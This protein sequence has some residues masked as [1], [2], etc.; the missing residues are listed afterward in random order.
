MQRPEQKLHMAAV[1][2][3]ANRCRTVM[4]EPWCKSWLAGGITCMFSADTVYTTKVGAERIQR[5]CWALLQESGVNVIAHPDASAMLA[6][7]CDRREL[8]FEPKRV[9]K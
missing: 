2:Y 8:Q 3:F 6:Q 5:E 4:G 9:R 7:Y 1:A